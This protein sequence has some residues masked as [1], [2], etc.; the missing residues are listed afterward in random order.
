MRRVLLTGF[1]TLVLAAPAVAAPGGGSSGFSGGGGGGGFSGGGGGS[2]GSCGTGCVTLSGPW[3]WIIVGGFFLLFGLGAL[4]I[5]LKVWQ[6]VKKRRE[7]V[8]RVELAAAEAAQDD[9][10]FEP[11]E[12]RGSAGALHAELF[13]AWNDGNRERLRERLGSD[14]MV[15]W[16][17]RLDDFVAK[18]WRNECAVVGDTKIEYV[19]LTNRAE[20]SEDRACVRVSGQMRDVVLDGNGRLMTRTNTDSQTVGFAEYWTLGRARG[21]WILLSIEQDA[22][23]AHNLDAPIVASPWSDEAR[24]HDEAVTELAVADAAPNV[25]ELADLD[26]DGD[27]HAAALDLSNADGRFAPQVLEA[28]ARRAV[29]AWAEAVDGDDAALEAIATPGAVQGL[30]YGEDATRDTRLVVRGP[31]LRALRITGLDAATQPPTMTVEADVAGRRYVENRDTAAVVQ[32]SKERET[33]FTERWTMAL[34]GPPDTP[35]QVVT[36]QAARV[37]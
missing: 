16:E 3:A 10:Y 4:L 23:G 19:G 18:G 8:A 35:W 30:L 15:E 31:D 2:G 25:A 6:L 22:E 14:L 34:S 17:R 12:L 13:S 24:L 33:T 7:R 27:A 9:A 26:F 37:A 5:G 28:A 36:A 1:L 11:A 20:E 29:A 32:G 21:R